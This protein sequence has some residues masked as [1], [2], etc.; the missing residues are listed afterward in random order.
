MNAVNFLNFSIINKFFSTFCDWLSEFFQKLHIFTKIIIVSFLVILFFLPG[1]NAIPPLDRDEARFSQASKQMLEDQ[2]FIVIKFQEELRSKKPIGI[3][4]LQMASASIFG[5]E[6]ISSY[7]IPNIV[8]SII[9]VLFFSMFVYN[10]SFRYF[11]FTIASSLTFSFFSSLVIATLLGFA[12]ELKQAKTDTVLLML[13][14]IQQLIFWKLYNYGKESWNK[15]KHHDHIWL[16]RFFWLTIAFGILIKGPISPL[17]FVVTLISVCILDRLSEKEWSISWLNLFLWFQGLLIIVI[18]TTPW[19][20]LAWSATDGSLILD[21]INEDFLNKVKSGQEN[22]WGPFGSHFIFLLLTFWP[23][24]LLLPFAGRAILNWKRDRLT[25]FLVSW[26]I[27]FWLILELTPTKLPHYILPIFPALILLILL[28][29]SSPPSG[30]PILKKI[31]KIFRIIVIVFTILLA[32][33]FI[34]ISLRFS[35][36]IVIF[37]ISLFLALMIFSSI[38]CGNIFYLNLNKHK[39]SPLFGM[40]IF[41]GISNLIL[42]SA[43]IPNLDKIHITPKIVKYINSLDFKPDTIVSTGYH[44]PSLVF[45]LGRDTLLL[46]ANETALVLIEGDNTLAIVEDRKL[47]QVNKTLE[48]FN[49]KVES[50]ISI[51]GYNLAKGQKIIIHLLKPTQNQE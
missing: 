24:V 6:N 43:I 22:H 47:K 25:R 12:I 35:S 20:Y 38:I 51:D 49:R 19:V 17:L 32:I 9:L 27:P 29:I 44:E 1:F 37:L 45:S 39:L 7:R 40:A 4:W 2:N 15:Y 10:I 28:G 36:N 31:S 33:A 11:D 16:T 14:T 48:K 50:L 3:Y 41:A 46:K 30:H 26:L 42:F 18:T 34:Y 23:M 5:K 13:C 8:A 21:A